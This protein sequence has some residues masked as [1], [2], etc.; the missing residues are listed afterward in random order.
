MARLETKRYDVKLDSFLRR[1][2]PSEE[3]ERVSASEP[4]VV[5]SPD[6]KR[7]HRHVILGHH[8]LY[9]TEFPPKSL[10][11]AVHLRDV[12]S[13]RMVSRMGTSDIFA[14]KGCS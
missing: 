11:T 4:C 7:V 12:Q 6:D 1:T 13:V 8:S 3:Y 9:L 14:K 2:L 5:L 10:K